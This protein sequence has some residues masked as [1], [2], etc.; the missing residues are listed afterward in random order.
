MKNFATHILAFLVGASLALV[1]Y[2]KW[3]E[4]EQSRVPVPEAEES[5]VIQKRLDQVL[6][7]IGGREKLR[8]SMPKLQRCYRN[9][10]S[11]DACGLMTIKEQAIDDEVMKILEEIA[12]TLEVNP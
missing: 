4:K 6:R 12:S 9:F 3:W 10:R 5:T 1:V 8:E 7:S 11:L 2:V